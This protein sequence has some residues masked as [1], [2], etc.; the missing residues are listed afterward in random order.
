MK[1][2]FK[3]S[4]IVF[5]VFFS[6]TGCN[7][8]LDEEAEGLL[9]P[10][11]FFQTQEEANVALNGLAARMRS[12]NV[13]GQQMHRQQT[14]G[15]DVAVSGRFALAGSWLFSLYDLSTDNG[16]VFQ[17][18]SD[19]Y[20]GV[21]D[22]NLLIESVENS[23]L[24][25]EVKQATI[26]QALFYRAYFYF[27]LTTMWGDVPFWRDA[28]VLE[29]V[30]LL[31]VS[32]LEEIQES[33]IADLDQAIS[34]N[35]LSTERFN[36]NG[37]RPTVW[38]ARMM[39]AHFHMFLEQWEEA[40]TELSTIITT[41]PHGTELMPYG[42]LYREGSELNNEIIFGVEY[43]STVIGS[44]IPNQVH[45][46]AA[47]ETANANAA[48]SELDVFT[49]AAAITWRRSFAAMYTENDD[50]RRYNVFEGHTLAD[51]TEVTFNYVYVPKFM[52]DRLPLSDPLLTVPDPDGQGGD[53]V[54]LM[55]LSDAYL[56]LAESEFRIAGSSP[57]ALEAI[58]IVRSRALL[59]D[60]SVLD[61]G[62]YYVRKSLGARW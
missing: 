60:L 36:D 38:S 25:D 10:T 49:R 15:T 17:I 52:R 42:D 59:D 1:Q 16:Q 22:A 7:D 3:I 35:S 33:M 27:R 32:P 48:F 4:M 30:S 12:N 19:L 18:W 8:F 28:L 23:S 20:A 47:G 24:S 26:S 44:S 14:M 39:K 21:R 6:L 40:R 46:N 31:G 56:L 29:E 61:N 5:A 58:N 62:G 43:L 54:R 37:A 11:S 41:S 2:L 9:T 13:S 55:T 34:S 53:S 45:P 51:G 57:A 50:R